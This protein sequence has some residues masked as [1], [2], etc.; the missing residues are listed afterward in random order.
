MNIIKVL[1][2]LILVLNGFCG[3]SN[4][5]VP[6]GDKTYYISAGDIINIS[7]FPAEEFSREVTVQPD[8][9]MEIPLLGSIKV[10]GLNVQDLQNI[11]IAKFSKYVSNPQITVN[12]RKF[13]AHKVAIIG[14]IH[15]PGYYEYRE[16]LRLLDLVAQAGGLG[17]YA[18]TSKV[19]IFRQTKEPDGKIK[20]VLVYAEL[21]K[22]L[23]GDCEKNLILQSGDIVY[24]PKTRFSTTS[25]WLTEHFIPLATLIVLAITIDNAFK[26]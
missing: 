24:V 16:G 18:K 7:V 19:R 8:G 14:Q 6:A 13:A 11:L 17:E 21:G 22:A 12:V 20:E 5:Q 1:L 15:S 2:S 26:N 9:T 23:K 10:Q 25:K 4:A 3:I